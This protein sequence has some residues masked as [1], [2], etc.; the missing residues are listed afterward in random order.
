MP[1]PAVEY[2]DAARVAGRLDAARMGGLVV[3]PVDLGP[4]VRDAM[5][6]RHQPRP[7]VL[8]RE[9]RE[10]EYHRQ[11][12]RRVGIRRLDDG[13]VLL[14]ERPVGVP[15]LGI[16]ARMPHDG[17]RHRDLHVPAPQRLGNTNYPPVAHVRG[18]RLVDGEEA[19]GDPAL[20]LKGRGLG[21]LDRRKHALPDSRHLVVRYYAAYDRP[22]VFRDPGNRL[23]DSHGTPPA[24]RSIPPLKRQVIP[25]RDGRPANDRALRRGY[26]PSDRDEPGRCPD[27][28]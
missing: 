4:V 2:Q 17:R 24:V 14:V 20:P 7:A 19:A 16:A 5:A 13:R 18:Q 8:V 12:H 15:S 22:T 25:R 28:P 9:G 27:G 23:L 26:T 11:Q 1:H 6:S 10:H 21:L 3:L